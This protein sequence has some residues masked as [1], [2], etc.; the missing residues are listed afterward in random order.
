MEV[1]DVSASKGYIYAISKDYRLNYN[2][3]LA[4]QKIL[5]DGK[6]NNQEVTEYTVMQDG[7]KVKFS[8]VFSGKYHAFLLD[9]EKHAYGFGSN[10]WGQLGTSSDMDEEEPVIIKELINT[11]IKE[12]ACGNFHTL[13]LSEHGSVFACGKNDRYQIGFNSGTGS[14]LTPKLLTPLKNCIHIACGYNHSMAIVDTEFYEDDE[15]ED[16]FCDSYN[17]PETDIKLQEITV[18]SSDTYTTSTTTT[19]NKLQ[20]INVDSYDIK[21]T[22][23]TTTTTTTNILQ[24]ANV[25]SY[26]IQTTTTTDPQ[27]ADSSIFSSNNPIIENDNFCNNTHDMQNAKRVTNNCIS[28]Q[29]NTTINNNNQEIFVNNRP[30]IEKSPLYER[31]IPTTTTDPQDAGSSIFSSNNPII[32]NDNFYNNTHDMQNAKRITNNCLSLQNSD[33]KTINNNSQ[34]TFVNN[35][36]LIENSTPYERHT[37][38]TTIDPQDASSSIF[39]SSN[40]ALRNNHFYDNDENIQRNIHHTNNCISLQNSDSMII[41]NNSQETFVNNRPLIENSTPY[42][43]YTPTT[44]TDPQDAS[45][46]IFSS[47]N[48]P[49]RNNNYYDNN[50]GIQ[51]SHMYYKIIVYHYTITRL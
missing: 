8:R 18:D 2:K 42:E 7:K 25:D 41:N 3:N 30:L 37:P 22:T 51:N 40:S 24:E 35:R 46:S 36:P 20:E 13:F 19:T 26:K 27:D 10:Q 17:I 15:D 6:K 12:I 9:E 47:N 39:S 29:N 44:T 1:I 34:E 21:T 31:Y 4:Y 33:S 5:C 45:S 32:E 16:E 28:L 43:R 23:T 38:T 48:T 49:L 50:N 14:V 11:P